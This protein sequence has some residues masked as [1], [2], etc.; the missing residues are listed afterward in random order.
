MVLKI[1][2]IRILKFLIDIK[3][4]NMEFQKVIYEFDRMCGEV[5]CE[6]CKLFK[7]CNSTLILTH[8]KRVEEV[9]TEWAKQ[10]PEPVYPTILE[11]IRH[12]AAYLPDRED[13]K[14]W[15]NEIPTSEL[16][17]QRIPKAAAKELGLVPINECGLDE[18]CE[19]SEWR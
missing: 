11:L 19:E 17:L 18:Y 3:E 14:S 8:P 2:L 7:E 1:T 13:G 6:D 12:I 16:V 9:V 5:K 15:L 4:I 10:N